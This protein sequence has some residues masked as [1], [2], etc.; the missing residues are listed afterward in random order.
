MV[1]YLF[2]AFRFPPYT[3]VIYFDKVSKK[4]LDDCVALEEVTFS[5]EPG[6]FVSVV[7]HS[8]AGKTTLL[9]MLLAEERPSLGKV[10]YGSTDIHSLN[11][12][13]MNNYRRNIGVVF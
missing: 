10:F 9:K 13:E 6:E 3:Y 5:I 12:N 11:K 4:Y 8:G 2:L 1:L 7:G